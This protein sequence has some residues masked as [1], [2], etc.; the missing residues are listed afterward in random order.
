MKIFFSPHFQGERFSHR[1]T[2][3]CACVCVC[4]KWGG[5]SDHARTSVWHGWESWHGDIAQCHSGY[6]VPVH[7]KYGGPQ[8]PAQ[9]HRGYVGHQLDS[10]IFYNPPSQLLH[11]RFLLRFRARVDFQM[12]KNGKQATPARWGQ[13]LKLRLE[14]ASEIRL[15]WRDRLRVEQS[16]NRQVIYTVSVQQLLLTCTARCINNHF[17]WVCT[18]TAYVQMCWQ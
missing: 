13:T 3:S 14:K 11:Q 4:V 10:S 18:G 15:W 16:K 9:P 6:Q 12:Q 1:Q 5:N 2:F 7:T 8:Q 17:R